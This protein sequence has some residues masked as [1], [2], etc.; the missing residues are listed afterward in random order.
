MICPSFSSRAFRASGAGRRL[1]RMDNGDSPGS[2]LDDVVLRGARIR[3]RDLRGLEIRDCEVDG[4]RIVDSIGAT[5]SIS[6]ALGAV[7]VE[8]VDV[9]DHVQAVLDA[10]HPGR[11][12]SREAATVEEFR[13]AWRI[14]QDRWETLLR[15]QGEAPSARAHGSVEGE[16]SLIET[17]RHLRFA[18][19]AW[20]GTAVLAEASPH[21]SWGLPPGGTPQQI[22]DRLGLDL[23]ATP[24]LAQVL[25]ARAARHAEVELVLAELT[26][27]E[28]ERVCAGSPGPG[29]P[30][31][32]YRVRRCLQVVLSEEV[33]HLRYAQRDLAVLAQAER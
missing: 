18:A 5:V 29:Y 19:D 20:I 3:G 21:H 27:Q 4:L 15:E 2:P 11:R 16:W 10:R 22:V 25:E 32:E 30:E 12:E 6:G 24:D 14:V 7:V 28:L 33:E 13:A 26:E 23:S 9:T 17:L 1:P 31:R 8:D